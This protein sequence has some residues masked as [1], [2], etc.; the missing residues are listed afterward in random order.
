MSMIREIGWERF[1][2]SADFVLVEIK[3]NVKTRKHHQEML[4]II[5]AAPFDIDLNFMCMIVT[6]YILCFRHGYA[7]NKLKEIGQTLL[8]MHHTWPCSRSVELNPTPRCYG[9]KIL[10]TYARM[11]VVIYNQ[12]SNKEFVFSLNI[13]GLLTSFHSPLKEID[14]QLGQRTV[15][16]DGYQKHKSRVTWRTI[17]I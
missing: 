16:I 15:N 10:C 6:V 1:I 5:R 2:V 12:T 17:K 7:Q 3:S 13:F 8:F 11:Y 4:N 14:C 9:V